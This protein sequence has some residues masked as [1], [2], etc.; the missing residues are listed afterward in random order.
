[1]ISS[2]LKRMLVIAAFVLFVNCKSEEP[3]LIEAAYPEVAQRSVTFK[4]EAI[5]ANKVDITFTDAN[6]DVAQHVLAKAPSDSTS[7]WALTISA[8]SGSTVSL[9]AIITEGDGNS[10]VSARI[11][12]AGMKFRSGSARG[13]AG[14]V[15]IGGKLP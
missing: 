6:A 3:R 5:S 11:N 14:T 4:V 8:D 10:Q 15:N 2:F 13:W 12:V 9:K 1:M 7:S